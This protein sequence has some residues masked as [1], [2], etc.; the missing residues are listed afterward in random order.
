MIL[1]YY[2]YRFTK[3]IPKEICE[4]IINLGKEKKLEKA[5]IDNQKKS[6]TKN[7]KRF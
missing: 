3:A 4:K 7:K 5:K 2:Y 1:N 6:G